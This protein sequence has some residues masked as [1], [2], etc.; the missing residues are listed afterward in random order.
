MSYSMAKL[1]N[2]YRIFLKLLF[3]DIALTSAFIDIAND[4]KKLAGNAC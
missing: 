4:Q 1:M 3:F 2:N